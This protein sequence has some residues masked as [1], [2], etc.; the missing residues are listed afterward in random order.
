MPAFTFNIPARGNKKLAKLVKLVE[1][2]AELQTLWR[3]ANV[4][5]IDRMK[6]NDHGAIHAKIVANAAL[7]MLR[8]LASKGVAPSIVENYKMTVEDAEVVV[9]LQSMLHDIGMAVQRKDHDEY[10]IV[11]AAGMLP[12]MLKPIFPK[13]EERVI[14]T[15]EVLHGLNHYD[16][17]K[18]ALTVEGGCFYIA[19]ALDM[20]KGRSRIPFEGGQT[21]VHAIS[22]QAI[23]D[24]DIRAGKP[25]EKPV[26]IWIRMN[27]SAGIFQID[28][29]LKP[30]V[31]ASGL[32]GFID[33]NAEL[34][35]AEKPI[36]KKYKM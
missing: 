21:S 25:G 35:G 19:D 11:L 14:V 13:T 24:V 17:S 3:C 18:R 27:N 22:A 7:Q 32:A 23:D 15:S 28:E 33:V 16:P 36:V 4:I 1:R 9:V 8:L 26:Q 6:Y 30:R 12:R 20:A 31:L 5:S 2:D 34:T 10:S 29:L